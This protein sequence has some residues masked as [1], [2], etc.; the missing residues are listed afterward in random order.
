MGGGRRGTE[1]LNGS[2]QFPVQEVWMR[3]HLLPLGKPHRL[4]SRLRPLCFLSLHGREPPQVLGRPPP[5]PSEG[6]CGHSDS[7]PHPSPTSVDSFKAWGGRQLSAEVMEKE[8]GGQRA[9][10]PPLDASKTESVPIKPPPSLKPADSTVGELGGTGS[11]CSH[12][13]AWKKDCKSS[14]Q[15]SGP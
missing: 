4:R 15:E 14:Y 7:S 2:Q 6:P 5:L 10:P 9:A 3:G 8:S 11:G 1:I 13:K 12:Q